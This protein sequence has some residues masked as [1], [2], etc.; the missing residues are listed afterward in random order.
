LKDELA[1]MYAIVESGG[2]QYR[3]EPQAVVEVE[4]LN[5]GV[6]EEVV[7]D[8]VLLVKR[9]GQVQVG[10]PYLEKARVICR[11]LAHRRGKKE[12]VFTYKA[13]DNV[14]RK[15]GHRQA[16]SRLKVEEIVMGARSKAKKEK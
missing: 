2:K 12:E 10:H 14:R 4:R 9:D 13:K 1:A 5:A 15:K 8:R 3:L 16:F 7:L 11:V 6:G